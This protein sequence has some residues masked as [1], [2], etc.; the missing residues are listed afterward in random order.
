MTVA[1]TSAAPAAVPARLGSMT[2]LAEIL[3]FACLALV[4]LD[5][6]LGVAGGAVALGLAVAGGLT[7]VIARSWGRA[8]RAAAEIL[9]GS[10]GLVVGVG[11]GAQRLVE[12]SILL[13]AATVAVGMVSLVLM[14][15]GAVHA[16]RATPGWWRLLALPIGFA[17]LQFG[18]MPALFG[19]TGA[20][21][22]RTPLTSA[23]PPGASPCSFATAD[24]VTLQAWYTPGR[25]RAAVVLLPG[26]GGNRGSTVDD[27]R[28]LAELG[29]GVL[30]VDARGTADSGGHNNLWGWDGTTDI[31]AAVGW[32]AVQ[33]DV[34][35]G[36]IGLVGL[37]MGGEQA[38]GAIPSVP[39]VSAVVSE[40]VQARMPADVWF[41]DDGPRGWIERTVLTIQ[42]TIADLWTDASTPPSL[43]QVAASFG[44][45]PV[46][47]IAADAPDERAVAADLAQRSVVV[48]VWQTAGIGH[49]GA[50]SSDPDEWRRRVGDFLERALLAD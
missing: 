3:A 15:G 7:S 40:G 8:S 10:V 27:A 2:L 35:P 18:L 1:A 28:A 9:A 14:L 17:V 4:V 30:A 43:R 39:L 5:S 22:A 31:A 20:H 29:Y 45:T 13:G 37:S 34:D 47:I 26:A 44:S 12:G 48:D 49:T 24:G 25:N 32:L 6:S 38:L 36:R 50:L 11:Y 19:T 46:L 21:G 16:V 42:W 23:L 41:I 33:A